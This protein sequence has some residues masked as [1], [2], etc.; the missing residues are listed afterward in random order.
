MTDVV[1]QELSERF[2]D[3]EPIEQLLPPLDELDDGHEQLQMVISECAPDSNREFDRAVVEHLLPEY[4]RDGRRTHKTYSILY[5]GFRSRPEFRS[6]QKRYF[7]VLRDHHGRDVAFFRALEHGFEMVNPFVV[8]YAL[9]NL[10]SPNSNTFR[11]ELMEAGLYRTLDG[12]KIDETND[13][14]SPAGEVARSAMETVRRPPISQVNDT[15]GSHRR[16]IAVY[17]ALIELSTWTGSDWVQMLDAALNIPKI[18]P[19]CQKKFLRAF[20]LFHDGSTFYDGTPMD[21]PDETFYGPHVDRSESKTAHLGEWGWDSARDLI[22][23]GAYRSFRR[24]HEQ[25]GS[26]GE[27]LL[28]AAAHDAPMDP[29]FVR[30]ILDQCDPA[31]EQLNKALYGQAVKG[32]ARF[33]ARWHDR[34]FGVLRTLVEAGADPGRTDPSLIGAYLSEVYRHPRDCED[35]QF[36]CDWLCHI[37]RETIITDR[38]QG[39]YKL[40]ETNAQPVDRAGAR[41]YR[42]LIRRGVYPTDKQLQALRE[43]DESLY[44]D[45]LQELPRRK[46]HGHEPQ[47]LLLA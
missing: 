19:N 46:R 38:L 1:Y 5:R 15:H 30:Y 17:A 39:A 36:V 9:I 45:L 12:G 6:A 4:A 34:P 16:I 37:G 14:L 22:R 3:G 31:T 32:M 44:R 18:S 28:Y 27:S 10:R 2:E 20:S 23:Y 7:R 43:Q 8:R 11:R 47:K 29:R 41:A 13:T 33:A 42:P 35:I 40:V 26:I 21:V 25:G 24:W